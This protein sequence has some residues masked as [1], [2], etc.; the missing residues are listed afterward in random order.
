[1]TR[2]HRKADP[3][4]HVPRKVASGT[5]RREFNVLR[6]ALRLAWKDGFLPKPLSL[7]PPNDSLPRDRYL[8]KDEARALIAACVTPHVKVFLSLAMFTGA[9]KGSILALTWERVNFATGMI[10]FQEPGRRLTAKRRA[11]V[12]MNN[13]LRMVLEEAYRVRQCGHVVEFAG[14]ATPSGLRWSFARLCQRAEL[15]WRPTPHH[16]KHSVISW[17]AMDRIP[18]EQAA[19]LVATDP[20]TLRRTYKKFDPAYLRSVTAALEL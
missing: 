15:T 3:A 20:A 18:I 7:T 1:M 19:D 14:K 11:I 17:L 10:D 12:P 16:I 2:P 9:R 8:T 6:A 4:R 13:S 5:L